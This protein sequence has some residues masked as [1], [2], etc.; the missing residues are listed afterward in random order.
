MT[1]QESVGGDERRSTRW[2]TAARGPTSITT[3]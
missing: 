1:E 2:A 3:R